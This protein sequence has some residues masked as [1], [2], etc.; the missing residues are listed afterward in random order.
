MEGWLIWALALPGM[1]GAGETYY[2]KDYQYFEPP[3]ADVRGPHTYMRVYSHRPVA[4][5]RNP[6]REHRFWDV[7]FGGHFVWWGYSPGATEQRGRMKARGLAVFWEPSAHALLD[8]GAHSNAL[9]NADYR[10]ALGVA[11]RSAPWIWRGEH[12]SW[13]LRIF[14]ESS[15]LGDEFVLDALKRDGL[16]A[17]AAGGVAGEGGAQ[18]FQRYNV[19]YEAVEFCASL[20]DFGADYQRLY[21]GGR[22]L[23]ERAFK[24][25]PLQYRDQDLNAPLR[26][27]GWEGQAGGEYFARLS[28]PFA[29]WRNPNW[30]IGRLNDLIRRSVFLDYFFPR[31]EEA[32]YW[33]MADEVCIR[34]QYTT[35]RPEYVLANNLVAG[36]VWGDYFVE[37]QGISA[38]AL[39]LNHYRG[40]NP[41]GQFRNEDL[42]YWGLEFRVR[43]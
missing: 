7:G 9:I 34:S 26:A 8:F 35:G 39:L 12:F 13:R 33:V 20:D 38:F 25:E 29:P 28:P 5:T 15:H 22:W 14:H 30:W 21:A 40:P 10:V 6:E 16:L 17:E 3:V 1:A 42:K 43:L 18:S 11:G 4:F 32:Y 24:A 27:K 2:R 41:H 23:D 36:L 31:I 37:D 19:G